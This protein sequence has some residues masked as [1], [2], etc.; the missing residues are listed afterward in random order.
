[1]FRFLHAADIH[2]DS[3]LR[4]LE[5]YEG[6][7]VD[8]IRTATRRALV[9]L[10]DLALQREVDFVVIAG[11]LYDGDWKDHNTGL[12]FVSQISRLREASIPVVMISGNHDAAN[13]MTKALQLPDHVEL[14]SHRKASTARSKQ[15]GELGVAI[16]GR[17]FA[18]S[19][20]TDNMVRDYPSRIDGMFN[21]GLLHTSLTGAEGHEPYAPCSIDELRQKQYDYWALGHVHTREVKCEDP[22]IVFCGNVQGRHIRE[23]GA[24]G[25]Y[26]V[27]VDQ[28]GGVEWEF[29]P[30]DVF[31][32][33]LCQVAADDADRPEQVLDRFKTA[34][35]DRMAM[36][37]GL[38]LAVRVVV[39]G[40]THAHAQ[41][42][43]DPLNWSNQIRA[44]AIEQAGGR[45]WIEKVKLRTSTVRDLA[46]E[47]MAD[48]PVGELLRYMT[49]LRGD[50]RQLAELAEV[51]GDLR[52]K[53]PDDLL[54]GEETL[55]FNDPECLRQWLDEVQPLVTSRLMEG[56]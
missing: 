20:E 25:C 2:L 17:S 31:R 38:P 14:L 9:N 7:P 45:V 39:T 19:A 5:Q 32:W 29:Q 4:G 1:M 41:L 24:K 49:E 46:P 28:R 48:G 50:D 16:H 22:P 43:A 34:L 15:L 11:D 13:R 42:A 10:V 35:A 47:A 55:D 21:I 53:L 6:A 40:R 30:L 52:R 3:P 51:L 18:R 54:R 8:E 26:L 56:V 36:H 37:D 12:F 44:A 33:D 23:T 27:S